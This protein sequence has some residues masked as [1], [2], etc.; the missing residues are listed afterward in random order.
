MSSALFNNASFTEVLTA[1]DSI[2]DMAPGTVTTRQVAAATGRGDSVVRPI[3]MRLV[4]AG[5][6][7]QTPS[8]GPRSPRPFA[9][10]NAGLW[11]ALMLVTARLNAVVETRSD[12][13]DRNS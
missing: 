7:D 1:A 11:E 9:R 6:L 3:M 8:N 4:D 13:T 10:A 2:L 12:L 5:L